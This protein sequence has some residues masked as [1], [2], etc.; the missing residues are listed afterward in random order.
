MSKPLK[1]FFLICPLALATLCV[2][3]F[4]SNQP[5]IAVGLLATL[6]LLMLAV[7]WNMRNILLYI[8]VLVSGPGAEAIAIYFGAWNYT[9]P[10]WGGIPIWLPFVWGNAALY[11]VRVKALIDSVIK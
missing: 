2:T 6:A 7:E 9:N 11:I 10:T 1:Q 3:S 4:Y 8:A 5:A